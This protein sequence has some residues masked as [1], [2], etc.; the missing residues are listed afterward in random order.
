MKEHEAQS[1]WR[2]VCW[3]LFHTVREDAPPSTAPSF[4]LIF[5]LAASL[6][7]VAGA[8]VGCGPASPLGIALDTDACMDLIFL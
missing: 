7:I 6:R 8:E 3:F 1:K 5:C 4:M 2:K